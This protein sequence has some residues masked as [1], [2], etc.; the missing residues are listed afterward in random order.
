M[1][2]SDARNILDSQYPGARE[3]IVATSHI[4]AA[5]SLNEIAQFT[6]RDRFAQAAMTAMIGVYDKSCFQ[7][8]APAEI[9]ERAY[10]YADAMLEARH[11]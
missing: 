10:Q 6:V 4:Q 7:P 1:K 5:E 2:R 8:A 3:H 11:K 9:A